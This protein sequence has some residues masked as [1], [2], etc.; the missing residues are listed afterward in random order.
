L[1][2][3]D[4]SIAVVPRV[5]FGDSD[6]PFDGF[7]WDGTGVLRTV[8]II[9]STAFDSTGFV[10]VSTGLV[11]YLSNISRCSCDSFGVIPVK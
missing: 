10:I 11:M 1:G 8:S 2:F 4:S 5:T 7:T 3:H 9:V 6:I